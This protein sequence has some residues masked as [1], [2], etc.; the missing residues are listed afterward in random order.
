MPD[1]PAKHQAKKFTFGPNVVGDALGMLSQ[2]YNDEPVRTM[3]NP[4]EQ[5]WA[6]RVLWDGGL[7]LNP[8]LDEADRWVRLLS[9]SLLY[10]S[11]ELPEFKVA[12]ESKGEML[13][14]GTIDAQVFLPDRFVLAFDLDRPT[15]VKAAL[16]HI[17]T[18]T[19]AVTH[20]GGITK[21]QT[22]ERFHY[23][24][25]RRV[26]IVNRVVQLAGIVPDE[27]LRELIGAASG[28]WDILPVDGK[29]FREH[30]IG[31]PPVVKLPN[32]LPSV[33]G[34]KSTFLGGPDLE[35]NSM[36]LSRLI[37]E[38]GWTSML[39]KGQYFDKSLAANLEDSA[40]TAVTLA[41]DTVYEGDLGVASSGAD[42]S[43]QLN[44]VNM[45]L[46]LFALSLGLPPETW[47]VSLDSAKNPQVFTRQPRIAED[48][49]RRIKLAAAFWERPAH[50]VAAA[51]WNAVTGD[52]F[53]GELVSIEYPPRPPILTPGEQLARWNFELDRGTASKREVKREAHPSLS[54]E[55]IDERLRLA[56]ADRE[57]L[58]AQQA[59]VAGHAEEIEE[60]DLA[61]SG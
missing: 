20:Q 27:R 18:D 16:L 9:E 24:D 14:R 51:V 34:A 7:G 29:L 60:S 44:V 52:T 56:E 10:L 45:F 53:T 23:W 3:A 17:S 6:E 28:G 1:E 41:S 30:K 40:K 58:V 42:L 55:E 57:K 48:R 26:A 31:T 8:V 32:A 59:L 5:A 49:Q 39:A 47:I 54:D 33:A 11:Y 4:E 61:P 35:R 43:G 50:K 13:R 12:G 2:L 21:F 38:C 19:V 22:V 25:S 15:K 36:Q 46:A 37:S